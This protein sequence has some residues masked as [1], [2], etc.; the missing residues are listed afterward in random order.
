MND[1]RARTVLGD[2]PA[3]SL[4]LTDS[5]D[6]LF[7]HAPAQR[8][9]ELDDPD[10]AARR[11]SDFHAA[12]GRT[13]VQWTPAGLGR[14]LDALARLSRATGVH[15]VAA[16]GRHL[17]RLYPPSHPVPSASRDQ[18][19]ALFSRDVV[20]RSCGLIKL[21]AGP[22]GLDRYQRDHLEAA[23]EVALATGVTV[24]VHLDEGRSGPAVL[25]V[26]GTVGLPAGRVV[27]GHLGRNAAV[28]AVV[29]AAAAGAWV[30][31]D[32][33]AP[34]SGV[35]ERALVARVEALTDHGLVGRLLLGSDT[36][37]PAAAADGP[38][39]ASLLERTAPMLTSAVGQ[40]VV[41][42]ALRTNPRRAWALAER[43][44]GGRPRGSARP[45]GAGESPRAGGCGRRRA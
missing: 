5:H 42:A 10:D 16:T 18:L 12:G 34:G 33:P 27:L 44:P 37:T 24:S 20:V 28:P 40:D 45:S 3:G 43:S 17:A 36:T 19:V 7:I 21:G 23:A 4:G 2:V 11:A 13:V 14:R 22:G 41:G 30:C 26:L 39:A 35:P 29:E 25:D 1:A 32:A 8:G 15:V 9:V 6:H 31:L 38:H